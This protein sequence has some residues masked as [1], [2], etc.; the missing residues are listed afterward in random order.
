MPKPSAYKNELT[1]RNAWLGRGS[2]LWPLTLLALV[3]LLSACQT[4]PTLP[5]VEPKVPTAPVLQQP[6]P[7]ESY[8]ASAHRDFNKWQQ[9]LTDTPPTSKP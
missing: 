6:L 3:M 5:C 1:L 4:Q 9:T 8:S 2:P 7:K